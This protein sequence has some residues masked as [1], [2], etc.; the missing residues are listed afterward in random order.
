MRFPPQEHDRLVA[1]GGALDLGQHALL[2][3]FDHLEPGQAELVGLDHVEDQPV[4]V[5]ARL[6]PVDLAAELVLELGDVR[7]A[8]EA[9]LVK[10]GRHR[11][12]IFGA[13]EIDADDVHRL[14]LDEGLA[15]GLH[16]RHPVAEEHVDLLAVQ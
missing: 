10:I 14:V 7:E 1:L 8:L 3:R 12:R 9:R 2:A 5:V 6:D 13:L 11:E 15:V 4:A 16:G